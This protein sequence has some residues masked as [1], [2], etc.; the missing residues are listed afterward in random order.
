[1]FPDDLRKDP[2]APRTAQTRRP[3]SRITV[4]AGH[5]GSGKTTLAVHLALNLRQHHPRVTLCDLDIVNPYFRSVGN[6]D[7][8]E[9]AGVRV[10]ASPLAGTSV[11]TPGFPPE[12]ASVFDDTGAAAVID[13]GGDDRGALAMGRYSEQMRHADAAVLLVINR[14]RPF[15]S[16][17][18]DTCEICREIEAAGKFR[19]TGIVNNSNLGA[20]TTAEDVLSSLPYS[21]EICQKL[22]IP[23]I[24][25]SAMRSLGPALQGAAENLWLLD[26]TANSP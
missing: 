7:L 25:V 19:F 15:S 23:L 24:A 12:A 4:L 11:E 21:E 18:K 20:E 10:I 6:R 2:S 5:Y 9:S 3:A 22:K 13:V 1:M 14:Y 16:G 17:A 8:L 26:M